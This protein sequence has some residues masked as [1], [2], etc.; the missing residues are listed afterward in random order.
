LSADLYWYDKK[1]QDRGYLAGIDR[2]LVF[3]GESEHAISIPIEETDG[4]G[5]VSVVIYL[6]PSGNW[7]DRTRAARSELV[8]VRSKDDGLKRT[9]H[10]S[11]K[12]Y[13]L[14]IERTAAEPKVKYGG[15][16]LSALPYHF[17]GLFCLVCGALSFSTPRRNPWLWLLLGALAVAQGFLKQA[18]LGSETASLVRGLFVERGLY[19]HHRAMQK[20]VLG[21]F[22]AAGVAFALNAE[23]LTPRSL[24]LPLR[25]ALC[26]AIALSCVS[27]LYALSYHYTDLLFDRRLFAIQL[28]G[29]PFPGQAPGYLTVYALVELLL[30]GFIVF[31]TILHLTARKHNFLHF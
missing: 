29:R 17:A 10:R 5:Y 12:C 13:A 18:H 23:R 30:S 19:F 24:R 7:A 8:R 15:S 9:R 27:F 4:L 26:G 28:P 6:S 21:G 31:S 16:P 11:R 3:R 2:V 22:A 1:R 20:F 25:L 14:S